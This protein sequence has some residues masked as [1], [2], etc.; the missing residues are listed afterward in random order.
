MFLGG[1]RE[2]SPDLFWQ[3][4]PKTFANNMKAPLLNVHG[5]ADMNVTS[6]RWTPSLGPCRPRKRLFE[7][8]YY[9]DEVHTFAK[10]K[11]WMDAM[12]KMTLF[13]DKHLGAH[14]RFR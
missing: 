6:S 7:V 5:T 12:P 3:A 4:S 14:V 8:V 10:K 9:P 13:F 1:N 2:A 11:T